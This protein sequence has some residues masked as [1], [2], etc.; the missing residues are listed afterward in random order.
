[1]TLSFDLSGPDLDAAIVERGLMPCRPYIA[2]RRAEDER[3]RA[4]Y[5]TSMRARTARSPAPTAGLHFTAAAGAAG[6][7]GR[8]GPFRHLHVGAGTFLP[9]KNGGGG[10]PSHA[11]RIR[12]GARRDGWGA[13]RGPRGRRADRLASAPPPCGS[14]KARPARTASSGFA[15]RRRSSYPATGSGGGRALTNFH[16][17]QI[18]PFHAGQRLRQACGSAVAYA[19]AYRPA[20]ASIPTGCEPDNSAR[21]DGQADH[22]G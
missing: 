3:D 21:P 9:V 17:A 19:Y 6:R 16:L 11:S 13:E 14:W 10:R 12:R 18:D 8:P 20:T 15:A 5:Q 7:E 22:S 1:V 2:A 4:D